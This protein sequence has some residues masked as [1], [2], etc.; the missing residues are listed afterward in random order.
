MEPIAPARAGLIKDLQESRDTFIV[1]VT[2]ITNLQAKFKPAPDR[3]S[4][5]EVTEHVVLIELSL[6]GRIMQESTPSEHVE[7]PERQVEVRKLGFERT[8]KRQAPERVHP[9][10]RYTSLSNALDAFKTNRE[11][12]LAYM[13]D[14]H[15]DL[16][17]RTFMHPF[18]GAITCHELVILLASH[19]LRHLEQVREIQKTPGYPSP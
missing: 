3:W 7:R 15:D 17:A 13:C 2:G 9:T 6:M 1:G 14:C 16:H 11:K 18:V 4:I 12:T 10:G 8:S 19:T 5:E